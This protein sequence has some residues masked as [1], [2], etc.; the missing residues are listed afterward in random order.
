MLGLDGPI[1]YQGDWMLGYIVAMVVAVAFV[2]AES[3]TVEISFLFLS[4]FN[5]EGLGACIQY[6]SVFVVVYVLGCI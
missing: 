5:F 4:P 6:Y 1:I 2:I 3:A